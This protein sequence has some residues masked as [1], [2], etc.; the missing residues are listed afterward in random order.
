M[1]F[2]SMWPCLPDILLL[3][4]IFMD[5]YFGRTYTGKRAIYLYLKYNSNF[6]GL[7]SKNNMN[8]KV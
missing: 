3:Q 5:N 7:F 8:K 2:N 4:K 1:Y 6:K